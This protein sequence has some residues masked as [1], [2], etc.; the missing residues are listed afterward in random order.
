MGEDFG[1]KGFRRAGNAFEQDVAAHEK[2]DDHLL[3]N[4]LLTDERFF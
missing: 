4:L 2:C 1:G 3:E